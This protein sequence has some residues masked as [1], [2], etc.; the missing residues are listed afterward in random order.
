VPFRA[1]LRRLLPRGPKYLR[2]FGFYHGLRLMAR[3]EF[4]TGGAQGTI[5]HDVPGF[6]P[7]TLR[8]T[9][10]DYSAFWQCLVMQQYDIAGIPHADGLQALYRALLQTGRRPVIVDCGANIGM[11]CLWFAQAF[12]E[13]TIVAV[14]P[15]AGN[16]DLLR[17]NTARLGARAIAVQAAVAN[18]PGRLRLDNPAAGSTAFRFSA[19]KSGGVPGHTIDELVARVPDGTLFLVKIDIEGGQKFLFEKNTEWIERSALLIVELE[20]WLFPWEGNSQTFISS[21]AG[22][23]Y[24]YV[25]HG[26]NI[27]C[28]NIDRVR[29]ALPV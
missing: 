29:P 20:D 24:D 18:A 21:M 25:L 3:A 2:N 19:D 7:A 9:L 15:E 11:S 5:T 6:G 23:N 10:G 14:E 17:I 8:R 16:F 28:F 26:E 13:A 27:L 22:R 4:A 12:P 1:S